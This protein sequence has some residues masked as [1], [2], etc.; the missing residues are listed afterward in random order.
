MKQLRLEFLK[1]KRSPLIMMSIMG[2][3]I[4]PLLL[5]LIFPKTADGLES[6]T[7]TSFLENVQLL[8]LMLMGILMFGLITSYVFSKEFEEDTLKSTLVIPI[9]RS[10]LLLDKFL[11]VFVW[12]LSLLFINVIEVIVICMIW[13]VE[14][15]TLSSI[16]AAFGLALRDGLIFLPLLTPIVF[17]TLLIRRYVA[18][19]VFSISVV[20]INMVALN[21]EVY[22]AYYPYTIPLFLTG[23]VPEEMIISVPISILILLGTGLLG[24]IGSVVYFRKISI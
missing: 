2:I 12:I 3:S 9:R 4:T 22:Y 24:A 11:V 6:V 10:R 13:G 8:N 15:V 20:V 18:G 7:F 16:V 1:I 5:G 17:V 23:P 14:G 19:I 21:S